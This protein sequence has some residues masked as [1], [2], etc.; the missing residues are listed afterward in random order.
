MTDALPLVTI[1]VTSYNNSR[2]VVDTLNSVANQSYKKIE[3]IILDDCSKD[4]SV[5]IIENWISSAPL[6]A[7]LIKNTANMGVTKVCQNLLENSSGKYFQLLASDDLLVEEKIETQVQFLETHPDVAMVYTD[8]ILIDENNDRLF[9]GFIQRNR[10]DL[11]SA[12]SGAILENL[13][14][15][16]F[17]PAP[18]ILAKT[19]VL[20]SVGGFD[21]DLTYEDYDMWLKVAKDHPVI[22]LPEIGCKYRVHRKS[23][24]NSVN[25]GWIETN[26]KTLIKHLDQPKALPII[27]E[28]L[29][30]YYQEQPASAFKYAREVFLKTGIKPNE[31]YFAKYGLSPKIFQ[32]AFA[33]KRLIR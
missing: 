5:S 23:M 30:M 17:I 2:Y 18:S 29:R 8:A 31:Y 12:P 9:G 4:N 20:K 27:L 26:L 13:L 14:E 21:I 10:P 16:N 22:F 25:L 1:G 15:G 6:K 33:L 28:T 7:T 11:L 3:L 19:Q 24:S 32:L